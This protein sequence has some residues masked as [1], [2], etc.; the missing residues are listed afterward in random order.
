[1]VSDERLSLYVEQKKEKK[2]LNDPPKKADKNKTKTKKMKMHDFPIYRCLKRFKH[3]CKDR[4]G[5]K[6]EPGDGSREE[7]GCGGFVKVCELGGVGLGQAVSL[8]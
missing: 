6:G 1:M 4:E 8:N 3:V 2:S 5:E 7:E